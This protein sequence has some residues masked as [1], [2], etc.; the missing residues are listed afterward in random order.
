MEAVV[1]AEVVLRATLA[2]DKMNVASLGNVTPHLHW[3]VI[4]RFHD[5]AFFPQ[6]IWGQRKRA[7]DVAQRDS[8]RAALHGLRAEL[9]RALL[10]SEVP[11]PEVRVG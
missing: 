7:T 5:D 10:R 3:H 4:A 11:S 6:P 8:R 2:P 9:A 1:A